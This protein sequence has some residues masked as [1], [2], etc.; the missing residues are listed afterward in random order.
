[1]HIS[2]IE[3]VPDMHGTTIL[4]SRKQEFCIAC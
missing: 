4:P 3:C 2:S 1:L